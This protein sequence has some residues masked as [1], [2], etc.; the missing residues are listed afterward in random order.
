[1]VMIDMGLSCL[2]SSKTLISVLT[3][4]QGYPICNVGPNDSGRSTSLKLITGDINSTEGDI[5][6]NPRLR[7][8]V[9]NQHFVDRLP[10]EE[11]PV[12]YLRRLFSGE[13]YQ[14]CRDLLG[15]YGSEGHAHCIP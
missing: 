15:R 3:W 9:Y 6:R 2:G 5:R 14:S 13:T 7:L 4:I 11:D 12:A 8:G 1:M 10:M